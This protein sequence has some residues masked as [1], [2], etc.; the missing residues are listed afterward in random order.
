MVFTNTHLK[1]VSVVF[2]GVLGP[3]HPA[4]CHTCISVAHEVTHEVRS[5]VRDRDY[6]VTGRNDREQYPPRWEVIDMP[7]RQIDDFFYKEPTEK[8]SEALTRPS[9][10]SM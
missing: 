4:Q 3:Q 8:S 1:H 2:D 10:P 9:G 5:R 7:Y 6:G